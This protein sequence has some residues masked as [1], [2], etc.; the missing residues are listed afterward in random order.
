MLSLTSL[1]EDVRPEVQ[2][3][4]TERLKAL[5]NMGA[6]QIK[7]EAYDVA[8]KSLEAVLRCQPDNVKALF[9]K[10]KVRAAEECSAW[11]PDT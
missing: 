3:I 7:V 11:I 9:R 10:G 2:P 1:Q 5:N 4:L 8:L 6:A